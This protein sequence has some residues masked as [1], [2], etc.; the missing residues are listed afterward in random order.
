MRVTN[1]MAGET[2]FRLAGA[3]LHYSNDNGE[4]V[5]TVHRIR[6][7]KRRGD[8]IGPGR[9][10]CRDA[11]AATVR[12]LAKQSV[13]RQILPEHV[14]Y[15]D[16][17][18]ALWFRQSARRPIF[19]STG[20]KE[21]DE[22]MRNRQALYPHLLFLALPR[23]LYVWAL[24][25][26]ERPTVDTPLYR[27]PLLNLYS[28]GHMCA[29][30]AKLPLEINVSTIQVAEKA[31]FETL[32]THSNYGSQKVCEHPG[33]HNGLWLALAD[34]KLKQFPAEWLARLDKKTVGHA[35]NL[36]GRK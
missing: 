33:G 10:L 16:S 4:S 17:A 6:S 29:G 20:K 28:E 35:L 14:L 30:T 15:L 9:G 23:S 5:A 13:E 36:E 3:L 7:D 8:A 19:F 34:R 31:F 2:T 27:A 25:D 22:A 12:A 24:A 32:F 26:G 18:R 1:R 11:L 21:F